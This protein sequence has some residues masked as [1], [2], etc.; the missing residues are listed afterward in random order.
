MA[1]RDDVPNVPETICHTARGAREG[2]NGAEEAM[3]RQVADI[4]A[5]DG[6]SKVFQVE[7]GVFV[8]LLRNSI[9]GPNPEVSS[10]EG[11]TFSKEHLGRS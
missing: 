1:L 4:V 11:M 10:L 8:V 7:G 3:Q 6:P 9:P 5:L 2:Q